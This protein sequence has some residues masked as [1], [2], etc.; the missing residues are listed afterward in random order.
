MHRSLVAFLIVFAV[1]LCFFEEE[2]SVYLNPYF[3]LEEFLVF[4]WPYSYTGTF[5]T[6]QDRS[7]YPGKKRLL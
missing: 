5:E 2:P 7:E 6:G 3:F 4:L 1:F